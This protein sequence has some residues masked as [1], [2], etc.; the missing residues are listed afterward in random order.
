MV[1]PKII[2]LTQGFG[3]VR[4]LYLW[5][6]HLSWWAQWLG[7]QQTMRYVGRSPMVT[8]R[9]RLF[10]ARCFARKRG[11]CA[12][13][14]ILT[15]SL[16]VCLCVRCRHVKWVWTLPTR[17]RRSASAAMWASWWGEDRGKPVPT[18]RCRLKTRPQSYLPT[19]LTVK[20]TRSANFD[21]VLVII[22]FILLNSTPKNIF[23]EMKNVFCHFLFFYFV[24]FFKGAIGVLWDW[25][26]VMLPQDQKCLNLVIFTVLNLT[27]SGKNV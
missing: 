15:R 14:R 3:H 4:R 13:Y 25:T 1:F 10:A 26:C 18:D 20:I 2:A 12:L 11:K 24:F 5:S 7:L 17:R 23:K 6:K 27:E 22:L 8:I 19:S 16:F 9:Q 21:L